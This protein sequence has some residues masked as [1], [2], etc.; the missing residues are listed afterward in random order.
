MVTVREMSPVTS[1]DT[2]AGM[3]FASTG[4]KNEALKLKMQGE[5]KSLGQQINTHQRKS[6]MKGIE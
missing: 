6:M 4:K 2:L 1:N 3:K 5:E